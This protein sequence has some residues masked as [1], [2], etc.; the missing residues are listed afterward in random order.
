VSQERVWKESL[1]RDFLQSYFAPTVFSLMA[2]PHYPELYAF[3]V[4]ANIEDLSDTDSPQHPAQHKSAG[5]H[6]GDQR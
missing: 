5:A 6:V 1:G 2:G 3:P 4:H